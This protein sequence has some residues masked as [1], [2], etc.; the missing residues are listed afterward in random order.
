MTKKNVLGV[1][2]KIHNQRE[3]KFVNII[4][5]EIDRCYEYWEK[6]TEYRDKYYRMADSVAN[7]IDGYYTALYFM[8]MIDSPVALVLDDIIGY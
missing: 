8:G 3:Q 2:I 4:T 6:S 1:T 7:S 5:E